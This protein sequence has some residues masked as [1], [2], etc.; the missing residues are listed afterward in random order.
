MGWM[1]SDDQRVMLH[2]RSHDLSVRASKFDSWVGKHL[3]R[4]MLDGPLN[5]VRRGL[6]L[7]RR[8]DLL[9]SEFIRP[10]LNLGLWSPHFRGPRPG[11]PQGG[12]ICGFPWFDDHHDHQADDDQLDAFL[13]AGDPPI[14]FT[15]GTAA[16][17]VP[18]D[19][20]ASAAASAHDL[21]RRAILLI[22]RKEYAA[23]YCNLPPTIRAFT[24]APFTTLLPRAAATVHHGGIGTTAQALRAGR[25]TVVV[26]LAHDQF[27]NAARVKRLGV[28]ET[29]P[30]RRADRRALTEALSTVLD[31]PDVADRAANLGQRIRAEHGAARAVD[32]LERTIAR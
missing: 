7:P 29:V 24:Y 15:L 3:M 16:V 2:W 14:V 23:R 11:D 31:R 30:H 9:I 21:G 17:H 27:D 13:N 10:G 5:R 32:A 26:P 28:S 1:T 4:F 18:G 19:F 22:G 6:G 12:V 8:R 20:Y 25:P